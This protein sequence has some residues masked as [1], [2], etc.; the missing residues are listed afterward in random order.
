VA[1]ANKR[2]K[3]TIQGIDQGANQLMVSMQSSM[4]QLGK[5]ADQLAGKFSTQASGAVKQ[6][7]DTLQSETARAKTNLD[8][9]AT[10]LASV[11][12]AMAGFGAAFAA[13]GAYAVKL[14]ADFEK[15]GKR[16]EAV[17]L[18]SQSEMK[19]MS[20]EAKHLGEVTEFTATQAMN[21][22]EV[23]KLAG[24]STGDAIAG[25]KPALDL[26][27]AGS[28]ELA[29]SVDILVS[30]M[31]PFNLTGKDMAEVANTLAVV[32]TNT[33][34]SVSSLGHAF[35][36]AAGTANAVG[37]SVNQAAAAL[38]IMHN[39]GVKEE[40]S[41]TALR[42][43]ITA[44]IDPSKEASDA[45]QTYGITVEK[46]A[47]G[48]INF[49]K[50]L[51]QMSQVQDKATLA[52]KVFTRAQLAGALAVIDGV[53]ALEKLEDKTHKDDVALNKMANT[54]RSGVWDGITKVKSSIEGLA[55]AMAE[56]LLPK[57]EAVL[58]KVM[59]WINAMTTWA[60]A[61]PVL[62]QAIMIVTVGLGA[63]AVAVGTLMLAVAG[64]VAVLPRI[65]IAWRQT[66]TVASG[67]VNTLKGA[68]A[69][70]AGVMKDLLVSL[71][72]LGNGFNQF[73]NSMRKTAVDAGFANQQ[74][75]LMDVQISKA[76]NRVAGWVGAGVA[77]AKKYGGAIAGIGLGLAQLS[78]AFDDMGDKWDQT[79]TTATAGALTFA[80][81][82]GPIGLAVAA[83]GAGIAGWG[84]VWRH[85]P[86]VLTDIV[87][88]TDEWSKGIQA[89]IAY[90]QNPLKNGLLTV[91]AAFGLIK[92]ETEKIPEAS[93]KSAKEMADAY[94]KQA[95][96]AQ[97][98]IQAL[99]K[100]YGAGNKKI[101]DT[102]VNQV[103]DAIW[104]SVKGAAAGQKEMQAA[105]VKAAK[106]AR[107]K[108]EAEMKILALQIQKQFVEMHKQ[109][110]TAMEKVKADLD[111]TKEAFRDF[112]RGLTEKTPIEEYTKAYTS[113]TDALQ[114]SLKTV[115]KTLNEQL[116]TAVDAFEKAKEKGAGLQEAANG[117]SS[118]AKEAKRSFE[119]IG[120]S[121]VDA[122]NKV[123]D[124]YAKT[125]KSLED[126]ERNH[127]AEVEAIQSGTVNARR[128]V[129]RKLL[130]EGEKYYETLIYLNQQ[131]LKA[132]ELE[133]RGDE[134][135]YKKAQEI[136][137]RVQQEAAG[138]SEVTETTPTGGKTQV[139]TKNQ[140]AVQALALIEQANTDLN[141]AE[142]KHYE[143]NKDRL[144]KQATLY[145]EQ[146]A[147]LEELRL[148][149]EQLKK[150]F[151]GAIKVQVDMSQ[152]EAELAKERTIKVKAK[153]VGTEGTGGKTAATTGE[154][155]SELTEEE[156]ASQAAAVAESEKT[157]N[158][159]FQAVRDVNQKADDLKKKVDQTVQTTGPKASAFSGIAE[160]GISAVSG[161][162]SGLFASWSNMLAGTSS[163]IEVSGAGA[164]APVQ[165]PSAKSEDES[166]GVNMAAAERLMAAVERFERMIFKVRVDD[167]RTNTNVWQES[168]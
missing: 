109:I 124:E 98:A 121:I 166:A 14:A 157:V 4:D 37:M 154:V 77:G 89:I 97:G 47:D 107:D 106:E 12:A 103:R 21:A 146:I 119:D 135:S 111:K 90:V 136:R 130:T 78:G 28:I 60:K 95:G 44:L 49:L 29:D 87:G 112:E 128:T 5:S 122:L 75:T 84:N 86:E 42:G 115:N 156:R 68:L 67:A 33:N 19:A 53:D 120:K 155:G 23:F 55:L 125:L 57:I 26:A 159:L 144:E 72:P 165:R 13:P 150:T 74:L 145:E 153:L 54:M 131:L 35:R 105:A 158:P 147:Q 142:Q 160:Q 2:L 76:R 39:A 69:G 151:E 113:M 137:K 82:L 17:S 45:F 3:L 73:G 56:G 48:H 143:A 59:D 81:A 51:R 22:F 24:I 1:D 10:S 83:I 15:A 38:G 141:A 63:L 32:A 162:F 31:R 134:E 65:G 27:S 50:I 62:A 71:V 79:Y 92:T 148:K 58:S 167:K 61:H 168:Y 138:L 118:L 85:L 152:V 8:N 140:A 102:T 108:L 133:S 7:G 96:S 110:Q 70:L 104:D 34:S 9:L 36:Y 101:G 164:A 91:L 64:L 20:D 66:G 132:R 41:G 16:V 40:R 114:G 18:A 129:F 46:S 43:I 52:T 163:N 100:E 11:G 117:L 99:F 30:I 6:F 116:Q 25:M 88:V 123:K 127:K 126:L 139:V 80:G 94:L 93:K 161:A 149:M